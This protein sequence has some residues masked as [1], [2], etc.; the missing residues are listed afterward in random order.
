M[1][2][3]AMIYGVIDWFDFKF[4]QKKLEWGGSQIDGEAASGS[5]QIILG[6]ADGNKA[7]KKG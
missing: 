1:D 4:C 7:E 2:D 6:N 3:V 5:V